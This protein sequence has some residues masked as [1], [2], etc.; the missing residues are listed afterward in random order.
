MLSSTIEQF[1][2][3]KSLQQNHLA[4][5]RKENS[6]FDLM[7]LGVRNKVGRI[8]LKTF[9]SQ[10]R[11]WKFWS[12]SVAFFF[13]SHYIHTGTFEGGRVTSEPGLKN[14]FLLGDICFTD[15]PAISPYGSLLA[16]QVL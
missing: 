15:L 12:A 11:I 13:A 4:L 1:S 16:S 7:Y 10:W 8:E 3:Y 5:M 6:N 9:F 14:L 2:K